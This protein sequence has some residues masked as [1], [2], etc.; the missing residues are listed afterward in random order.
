MISTESNEA[1]DTRMGVILSLSFTRT[2]L[3][4]E[5]S[6]QTNRIDLQTLTFPFAQA[7]LS[8]VTGLALLP[9]QS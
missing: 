1:I 2:S 5:F 8:P 6:N 4:I 7:R 9:R 3:R